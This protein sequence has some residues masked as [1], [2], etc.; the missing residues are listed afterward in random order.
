MLRSDAGPVGFRSG[1]VSAAATAGGGERAP[2]VLLVHHAGGSSAHYRRWL[3]YFP[4][5]WTVHPVELAGSGADW[6][7][8]VER[9][10]AKVAARSDQPC[11]LFGHSMGGLLAHDTVRLLERE[12][13]RT[14]VWTGLSACRP[15]P[16]PV[17]HHRKDS[18]GLR[19]LARELG[20][21]PGVVLD[22]DHL[23]PGVEERLRADLALLE[24]RDADT[25]PVRAP[26]SLYCGELDPVAGPAVLDTW[27]EHV[28]EVRRVRTYP[29]GHF[30]FHSRLIRV[31]SDLTR[32]ITFDLAD[33]LAENLAK[34]G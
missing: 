28:T 2:R 13:L 22:S 25:T 32:D 17:R 31:V 5:E 27:R 20:G 18:E 9:L 33:R 15:E 6:S 7:A 3:R 16:T 21:L 24:S 23:W 14:P 10:A 19:E 4:Q 12:G 8:E 30:Y 11:A 26:L 34:E 1:T 29:G